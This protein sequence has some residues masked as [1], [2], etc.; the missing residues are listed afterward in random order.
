MHYPKISIVTPSFN[1]AQ[2]LEETILSVINQ[3]YPNLEYII[4]DGG[5]TDNSVEIIKK[6]EKHLAYWVS[7]PDNGHGD[8]LNKGFSKATGEIMAWLNSD[9]KYLPWT[10]YTVNE[11][12]S[13]HEAVNWLTGIQGR[14]NKKGVITHTGMVKKNVYDY[15]LKD[16]K[17]IQQESTFWRRSLWEKAGAKINNSYKLMVDGELW[18]RFFLLD[19]L[20]HLDAVIGGYRVHDTNRASKF[21]D[22]VIM[23]MN[24]ICESLLQN[25][26]DN[27]RNNYN[28]ILEKEK[29]INKIIRPS[30]FER[31]KIY[32][33]LPCFLYGRIIN[34]IIIRKKDF[35]NTQINELSFLKYKTI[36]CVD[37]EWSLGICKQNLSLLQQYNLLR[38]F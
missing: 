28:K 12:F 5:S 3:N 22:E 29:K 14:F 38:F 18:S 8:A 20:W 21:Y 25:L 23:E 37:G 34:K 30:S 32:K 4:I 19:E 1:Q 9:D 10:L 6:Y 27:Q 26:S 17:W 15:I 31:M 7:E 11:I 13:K 36:E 35:V 2:Y 33:I 16:Y 24:L